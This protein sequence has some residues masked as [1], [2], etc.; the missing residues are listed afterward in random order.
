[1]NSLPP[2]IIIIV[3]VTLVAIAASYFLARVISKRN[4]R[5]PQ[6]RVFTISLI[7]VLAIAFFILMYWLWSMFENG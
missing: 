1:M 2:V 7:V 3:V 4:S 5:I 6:L